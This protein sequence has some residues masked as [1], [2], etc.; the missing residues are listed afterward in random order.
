MLKSWRE[1]LLN[2]LFWLLICGLLFSLI[3]GAVAYAHHTSLFRFDEAV[4]TGNICVTET[5]IR[6]LLKFEEETTLF[7]VNIQELQDALLAKEYISA[8]RIS[9]EF[10]SRL[11]I[12]IEEKTPLARLKCHDG[13]MILDL[14]GGVLE[15]KPTVR[16]HYVLPGVTGA[17]EHYTRAGIRQGGAESTLILLTHFLRFVGDR[18][19]DLYPRMQEIHLA[20]DSLTVQLEDIPTRV[21]FAPE[22]IFDQVTILKAF[23]NALYEKGELADYRY[24]DLRVQDQ[25]VVREN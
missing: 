16:D 9:R 2:L 23:E 3:M 24:V 10:P 17:L 5:E 1:T 14:E 12:E 22:G 11:I 18:Y 7:S 6:E 8:V 13:I 25:V 4:I 15:S 19:V 20:G 21:Y